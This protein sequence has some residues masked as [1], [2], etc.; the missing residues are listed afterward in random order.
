MYADDSGSI[1]CI[2]CAPGQFAF[3]RSAIG[4]ESCLAGQFQNASG[5]SGCRSCLPGS[6]N[7]G[8]GNTGCERVPR[9]SYVNASSTVLC[10][11]GYECAGGAADREPCLPGFYAEDSGSIKCIACPPGEYASANASE[12][13]TD[14]PQGYFQPSSNATACNLK[15]PGTIVLSRVADVEV[16]LG[17]YITCSKTECDFAP[18]LEGTYG[19]NPPANAT[20]KK[21]LAGQPSFNSSIACTPCGKGTFAPRNG[22]LC[23]ECPRGFFQPQSATPST[24]CERCP[25]GYAQ[26]ATGE[27]ACTSLGWLHPEDCTSEQYLN[28]TAANQQDWQCVTCPA[29]G[30]CLSTNATWDPLGPMFGFWKIPA[31]DRTDAWHN[32]FA[33]CDYH[34]A[35]LGGPNPALAG[36]YLDGDGQDLADKRQSANYS[37]PCA[38]E[39]GFKA[40]SRLCHACA[41]GHRRQGANQCAQ[42]PQAGQNWGL[43]VLG[44][45][46]ILGMLVYVVS[47]TLD[48]GDKMDLSQSVQKIMLS[49]LQVIAL[50]QSFP[51]RWP[52]ALR[53][54]F[55]I[56]G[57]VS[58]L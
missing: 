52:T 49:Y 6:G 27:S 56:Q 2:D 18:C 3:N 23:R 40:S 13:C 44:V 51:L 57:A 15:T 37:Q 11:V 20:C 29:G 47:S 48:Q 8:T 25:A 10:D 41:Q 58:T 17:S 39:L 33:E 5:Q 53:T 38:T 7:V 43:I 19:E 35:C 50:A 16:P 34:P 32:V 14:C 21:C 55:E 45:L 4:C 31:A 24:R 1:K 26:K 9:G 30:S 54:L 42:C 46:L 36:R 12:T 28:N 22:S